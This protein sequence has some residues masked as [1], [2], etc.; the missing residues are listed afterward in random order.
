MQVQVLVRQ[1]EVQLVL[2]ESTFTPFLVPQYR[3]A[4]KIRFCCLKNN[5][6]FQTVYLVFIAIHTDSDFIKTEF[7]TTVLY[8]YVVK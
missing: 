3:L 5:G 1:L 6:L 2:F 7:T 4:L 8:S